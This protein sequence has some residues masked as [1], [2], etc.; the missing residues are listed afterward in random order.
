MYPGQLRDP[1][2][3]FDSEV[4]ACCTEIL[5][6]ASVT[7]SKE[8]FDMRFVV[9]PIFIAGFSTRDPNEKEMALNFMIEIEKHGYGGSTESARKLLQ[10]LYQKQR[11]AVLQMG[12]AS[13]VDWIEEM[14]LSGQ[15]LVIYGL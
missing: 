10:T 5:H 9:F 8:R 1:D 6:A 3:G 7:L 14:E 13:S 15:R 12:D 4:H 2:P 11:V